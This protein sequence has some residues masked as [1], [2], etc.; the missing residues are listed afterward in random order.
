[1]I[2]LFAIAAIFI[3]WLLIVSID[4]SNDDNYYRRF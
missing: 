1:M 2:F 4:D 3:F